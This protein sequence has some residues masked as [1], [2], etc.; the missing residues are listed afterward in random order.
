MD[1]HRSHTIAPA[2]SAGAFRQGLE[3]FRKLDAKFPIQWA[4]AFLLVAERGDARL[5]DI[6]VALEVQ[7]STASMIVLALSTGMRPGEEGLDLVETFPDPEDRRAK[8]VRLTSRGRR[9]SSAL[10]GAL[11]RVAAEAA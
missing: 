3:E 5:K 9:I 4:S 10:S 8:R 1:A 6:E 11:A 2:R 7:Q